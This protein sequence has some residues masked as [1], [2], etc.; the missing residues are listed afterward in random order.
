MNV[1]TRQKEER[2]NID[3]FTGNALKFLVKVDEKGRILIPSDIRKIIGINFNDEIVLESSIRKNYFVLY[4]NNFN[5]SN[6]TLKKKSD[7]K[8]KIINQKNKELNQG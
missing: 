4:K 1:F 2:N 5:I 3:F 6:V 7:K 8:W